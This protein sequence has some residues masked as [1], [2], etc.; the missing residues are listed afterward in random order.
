MSDRR[1]RRVSYAQDPRLDAALARSLPAD[2]A[3]VLFDL[4]REVLRA[5]RSGAPLAIVT[6]DAPIDSDTALLALRDGPLPPRRSS[7][8]VGAIGPHTV[9]VVLPGTDEDGAATV[10][11]TVA[12]ADPR[13]RV[14]TTMLGEDDDDALAFVGRAQA[15]APALET[16]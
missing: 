3:A 9:L 4:L 10:A 1:Y 11:R 12:V 13:W 7:D 14:G 15:S 16:A 5:R 8:M 6:V 2:A